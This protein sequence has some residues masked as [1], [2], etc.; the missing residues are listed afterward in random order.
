MF[1][2]L[3]TVPA[4]YSNPAIK[5]GFSETQFQEHIYKKTPRQISIT[6]YC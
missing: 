6:E 4:P 3:T 5:A 1:E 2:N